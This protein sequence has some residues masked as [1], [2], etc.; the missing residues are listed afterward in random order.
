MKKHTN[1]IPEILRQTGRNLAKT[2]PT[3]IMGLFTVMLAVLIFSF[4]LLVHLN[5]LTIG[6]RLGEE[7]RLT[8]YLER[9]IEPPLMARLEQQIRQFGDIAEVRYTSRPDA[10][11]RFADQLGEERDILDNLDPEFLP[12]SIEVTPKPG[13]RGPDDLERLAA[14]LLTLPDAAKVQYGREWLQRFSAFNRI[15][16]AVVLVSGVLLILNMIFTISHSTRL[17][18]AAR[19]EEIEILRLLGASRGYISFPFLAEGLLQGG[20]GSGLGMVA[21]LLFYQ[22]I[23]G[24]VADQGLLGLLTLGFL[25]TPVT[26]GII[27]G[28][29]LLCV[30]SSLLVVNKSLRI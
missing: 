7:I 5:M 19:R 28:S 15:L 13:L 14:H 26:A 12:P 11:A 18:M 22:R 1:P 29:T 8:V 25:P 4:F 27:L 2:W 20:M 10:F 16:Q 9:E 30:T 6:T 3:Q 24:P 21:L 23:S 17:A